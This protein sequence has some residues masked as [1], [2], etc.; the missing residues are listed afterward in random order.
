MKTKN[1]GRSNPETHED[2]KQRDQTKEIF[3][4][5]PKPRRSKLGGAGG[6]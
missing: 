4:T 3:L 5:K 2:K 1:R 6:D